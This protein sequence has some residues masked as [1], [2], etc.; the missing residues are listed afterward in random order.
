MS[1]WKPLEDKN[2]QIISEKKNAKDYGFLNQ[3]TDKF[4][5]EYLQMAINSLG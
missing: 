4:V 3:A 5:N 2:P 1:V